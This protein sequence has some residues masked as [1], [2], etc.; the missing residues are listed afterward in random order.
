[1]C[2]HQCIT[3][4][5]CRWM[6]FH[7]PQWPRARV[8]NHKA[9]PQPK[10][11]ACRC[12]GGYRM[13]CCHLQTVPRRS[14]SQQ[15]RVADSDPQPQALAVAVYSKVSACSKRLMNLSNDTRESL[16]RMPGETPV[17]FRAAR[18]FSFPFFNAQSPPN[19]KRYNRVRCCSPDDRVNRQ[20]SHQ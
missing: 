18:A 19:C 10:T 17:P 5:K 12:Q 1:M 11:N 2:P 20:I 4:P 8:W 14:P 3:L 6:D 15:S 13:T 9:H 7:L 16:L